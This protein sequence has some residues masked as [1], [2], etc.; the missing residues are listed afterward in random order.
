MLI[1]LHKINKYHNEQCILKDAS[2]FIEEQDKIALVGRNGGGKS[3]LLNIISA[4]ESCEY[5]AFT[6]KSGMRISY[7]KQ[8]HVFQCDDVIEEMKLHHIDCEV[9]EMKSILNRMQVDEKQA[10]STMSGGQKKRLSL[11]IALLQPCDLLILDEPTNHLDYEMITFLENYLIKFTK[12]IVMVSHDRY[13]LERIVNKIVEIEQGNLYEYE[14]NYSKYL[15]MKEQRLQVA[16]QQEQKRNSFLKKEIEWVR[17]GVQARTTKSKDRLQ[18]FETLSNVQKVQKQKDVKMLQASSRLGKQI[19]ELQDVSMSYGK[20]LLFHPFSYTAKRYERVGILGVNGCGKSTLLNIIGQEME[21]SSGCVQYGQ[22]V[23]I[24]YYKQTFTLDEDI[25]VIDYIKEEAQYIQSKEGNISASQMCERFLFDK[26]SQYKS[27]LKLSGGERRRLYLL[28]TLMQAPNVLLLDEPTNDLDLDTL[29]ILEEYL[30]EFLGNVICV[31]HDRYFLDKIC[32]VLFV[33][34]NKNI[35]Q[36]MDSY[37][38]YI[39]NRKQETSKDVCKKEAYKKQKEQM[40][41]TTLRLSSKE[42]K[43]LVDFPI[44]IDD[45]QQQVVEVD[46]QMGVS[47]DFSILEELSNKRL[48]LQQQIEELSEL[49]FVLLEKEEAFNKGTS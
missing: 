35:I 42:K 9:Y 48:L 19:L 7:L 41:Q 3:T 14:A 36:T 28:R 24:A 16:L 43:Q 20:Q 25:S 27:V 38:M 15:V 21:A 32:D 37:T 45:L 23:K 8:D 40:K 31:S 11:A 30:E 4:S 46:K 49:Y 18:R 6:K 2:L 39:Q 10:I 33:F 1:S 47:Q 13:F 44:Q 5:E 12:A 17:A 29:A 34:E 22:T 26:Q